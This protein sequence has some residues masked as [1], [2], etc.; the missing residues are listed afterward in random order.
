MFISIRNI[1]KVKAADIEIKGITVIAGENN[2]GKSTIGRTLFCVFNSFYKIDERI[3]N[4]RVSYICSEIIATY[5]YTKGMLQIDNSS[6]AELIGKNRSTY[7]NNIALLESDIKNLIL[8]SNPEL[9]S[10][11]D[12][13]DITALCKVI[14]RILDITDFEILGSILK[15][16]MQK[17]FKAQ[18]NNIYYP[19][20]IS[21]V[22]LKM[23][24]STLEVNVAD[25]EQFCILDSD[26]FNT[27]VIYIDDPYT[28]DNISNQFFI[29]RYDQYYFTHREHLQKLLA[30]KKDTTSIK[31]TL[32]EL[33]VSKRF[34]EV[35]NK[36]NSVCQGEIV[37]K[38]NLTYVYS[39]NGSDASI[40]VSNLSTGLKTF[41]IIKTLLLNGSLTDNGIIVLDEPEIHLHP[42]WQLLLAELIVLIQKEFNMHILLNTHSP[43]F[44]DAIDVFSRKH[45]T[46]DK[47]KYYLS[48]VS[49][50]TST[51]SDVT[52]SI[53]EI[54]SKL[55][56]PLQVLENMRYEND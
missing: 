24:D 33:I 7:V 5:R 48:N 11:V 41:A 22:E 40:D 9:K 54:Y 29:M 18:I 44:L 36:L 43:Y 26:S 15:N 32:G 17:E 53:E 46:A 6:L 2:S 34:T 39:E 45:G 10:L 56:R 49:N 27:E 8:T 37:K 3:R 13:T 31:E 19:N 21:K 25:N 1:G 4:E 51:F 23:K 30:N 38:N 28:V 47:C 35:F 50:G 52:D 55:A 42:E 12:K 16:N 14:L 20:E